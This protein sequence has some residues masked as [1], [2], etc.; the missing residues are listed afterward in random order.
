MDGMSQG[1][2]AYGVAMMRAMEACVPKEQR[3]F[4]DPIVLE[5]LPTI[6]RLGM[7][8]AWW[9]QIFATMV[10]RRA[11]GVRGSILCRT[12]WIDDAVQD[13]FRRG[14]RTFVILGAG[15]DTPAY[16]LPELAHS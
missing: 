2:S 14:V 12:R 6:A 13:A 3:L 11:P 5:L 9:R 7:R 1:R 10:D 15:F 4:E 16:R 8:T